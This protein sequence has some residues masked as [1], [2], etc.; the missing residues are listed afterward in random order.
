MGKALWSTTSACASVPG[1]DRVRPLTPDL[2]S[3]LFTKANRV[4][5]AV[6]HAVYTYAM[7]VSMVI[8]LNKKYTIEMYTTRIYSSV[9]DAW[10]NIAC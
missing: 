10:A 3:N 1:D 7:V 2:G 4:A 9:H 5:T 8:R 6:Y